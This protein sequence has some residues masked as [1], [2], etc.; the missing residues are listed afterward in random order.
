MKIQF[1]SEEEIGVRDGVNVEDL[2][3]AFSLIRSRAI[4]AKVGETPE[5]RVDNTDVAVLAPCVDMA[6]H[7]ASKDVNALKKIGA[8]DGGGMKGSLF[9]LVNGGTVDGGG[10]S[11]VLETRRAV[12]KDEEITISYG[13]RL[14]NKELMRAYGFCLEANKFDRLEIGHQRSNEETWALNATKVRSMCEEMEI[15]YRGVDEKTLNY[16]DAIVRSASLDE[17]DFSDDDASA[18]TTTTENNVVNN[19]AKELENAFKIHAL[20]SVQLN[21]ILETL[22]E[23]DLEDEMA[24]LIETAE[25]RN[26]KKQNDGATAFLPAVLRYKQN[27]IRFLAK[28]CEVLQSY[29]DWLDD[30][31]E[32]EEEI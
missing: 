1:K 5:S 21:A 8:S 28:G 11:V 23:T 20:W 27:H 3:Y 24:S 12:K 30:D 14:D 7:A 15:V 18:A 32:E 4:A 31:E 19:N 22:S 16:V 17:S 29:I 26:R 10:G 6:N 13:P 25:E 9:R 2:Y